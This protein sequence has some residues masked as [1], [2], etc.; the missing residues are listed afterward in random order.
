M[1]EQKTTMQT[2]NTVEV[3]GKIQENK[4]T[5]EFE[6]GVGKVKGS[7]V[8]KYGN[9]PDQQCEVNVYQSQF[10]KDGVTESKKYASLLDVVNNGVS[11]KD[12]T[13]EKPATVLRINGDAPFCPQVEFNEYSSNGEVK[14]GIK[15]NKGFGNC[16]EVDMKEEDFKAEFDM[17]VYIAKTPKMNGRKLEVEGYYIDYLDAIKPINFV[18]ENEDLIEGVEEIAKGDTT[19]FWG[20]IKVAEIVTESNK[21]SG[22]GG[23]SKTDVKRTFTREL[24]I[25]GGNPIEPDDKRAIDSKFVKAALVE[26]ETYLANLVKEKA[27]PTKKSQFGAK[28]KTKTT[29][30]NT[31]DSFQAIEGDDDIPF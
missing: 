19:E 16:K 15:I 14:S 13:E 30:S 4:L 5:H 3:I 20:S 9:K 1:A 10:N 28:T 23:K 7:V 22:F 24:I 12:A 31:N 29:A 17:V 27:T 18:V 11:A 25:E 21:K 2:L 26:R 6:K 8:I